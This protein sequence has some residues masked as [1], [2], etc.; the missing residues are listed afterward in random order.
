MCS[1]LFRGMLAILQYFLQDAISGNKLIKSINLGEAAGCGA[2]LLAS[3]MI[4]IQS[5]KFLEVAPISL[6]LATPGGVVKTLIGRNM[7]IPT[8]KTVIP[9]TSIS[10]Q[11]DIL[12]RMYGS[13]QALTNDDN[14]VGEFHLL[15]TPSPSRKCPRIEVTHAIDENGILNASATNKSTLWQKTIQIED[16]G[17]LLREEIEQMIN[18]SES[19]GQENEKQQ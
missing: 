10:N 7:K 12:L 14:L 5:L 1:D 16:V 18:G 6:H 8:K 17:R 3:D 19:L 4:N 15:G 2:A 9:I 11:E 13:K